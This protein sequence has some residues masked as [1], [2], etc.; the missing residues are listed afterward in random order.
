MP[1]NPMSFW[2]SQNTSPWP[3]C[4]VLGL[5]SLI[6][7]LTF[8]DYG[9]TSDEPSHIQYGADI[10]RWY[11]SLFQ[12]RSVF[13]SRNTWLYGGAFDATT[14][15]LAR[16]L[17][18]NRFDA[19]HLCTALTG[20]LGII[21]AYRLGTLLGSKQT[22]LLAALFLILTPRY[23]GH[24]FNNP[25]DLPFAICYLGAIYYAICT[26]KQLPNPPRS[27]IRKTGLVLGFT[28]G[29]RIGGFLPALYFGLF[30][31]LYH[32]LSSP[33]EHLFHNLLQFLKQICALIII[34]WITM[35]L[36]WPWGQDR[37]LMGVWEAIQTFSSFPEIHQSFFQGHYIDS[38]EIPR[39]YA[40]LWFLLTLPEFLLAGLATGIYCLWRSSPWM[41]MPTLEIGLLITAA[42]FPIVYAI[43]SAMPLYDG[44]RH[45]LFVIP[46]LAI[47]AAL[48]V[49]HFLTLPG[50]P[51]QL[52][53]PILAGLMLL[54]TYDMIVLHPNQYAYFNRLFAGGVSKASANYE[55]DYWHN[56]YKQALA[57][58]DRQPRSEGQSLRLS[59]HYANLPLY[60][61]NTTSYTHEPRPEA[62]DIYLG[63]TRFDKHRIIP[64]EV[65]HIVRA[66]GA[67]LLYIIRP[68]STFQNDPL[69]AQSAFR[70]IN[71]GDQYKEKGN[72]ENALMAYQKA[73]A[74]NPNDYRTLNH[75]GELYYG[76][77]Q[78]TRAAD[79]F[80]KT[81]ALKPNLH[82]AHN[83]L[84]VIFYRTNQYPEAIKA[85]HKALS[86]KFDFASA[87]FN[88][89]NALYRSNKN[90]AAIAAYQEALRLQPG[91]L[92]AL[93]NLAQVYFFSDNLDASLATYEKMVRLTPEDAKTH[94]AKGYVLVTMNRSNEALTAFR[95]AVRLAPGEI[96][97]WE[98][99]SDLLS[100]QGKTEEA[101]RAY[102]QILALD[103]GHAEAKRKLEVLRLQP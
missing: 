47:L 36:F 28:L 25:K 13:Q 46:P 16:F 73:I 86:F 94:I 43:A 92:P 33:R 89:A 29:I 58:L 84:G 38:D 62:A 99:L 14:A 88:L 96:M 81:I 63:V 59:S 77:E 11:S 74:S 45:L 19:Q 50:R 52:L 42:C 31:L 75:I 6:I 71:L 60:I 39:Y 18:F 64:G 98:G 10:L 30:G 79:Y 70:H 48:G 66:Q 23:Y 82:Q 44:I 76:L 68:D 3:I 5:Y 24:A 80:R 97:A 49:S 12:D 17:P 4:V 1:V 55:T 15:L 51:A 35:L 2:N 72:I 27:L 67:A 34:A 83:N 65:V 90:E 21:V 41:R 103:P 40:P 102:R 100:E 87:H 57:W 69:F 9:I 20:L 7:L 91:F 95:K 54:T 8:Q 32:L 53:G 85:F 37:P 93:K 26:L 56:S 61:A 22:G 78:Y 101:I